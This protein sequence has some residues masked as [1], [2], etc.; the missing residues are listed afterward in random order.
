MF[1]RLSQYTRGVSSIKRRFILIVLLASFPFFAAVSVSTYIFSIV[2]RNHVRQQMVNATH[3]LHS[4]V[5]SLLKANVQTYLRSKVE[6]GSDLLAAAIE[7]AEKTGASLEETLKQSIK[8]LLYFQV[9]GSG[10]FYAIDMQGNVIFHPDE[11]IVGTDQTGK[12]PVDQQLVLRSGYL[13]YMWQNT[14]ESSPRRKALYMRY[15]PRLGWILTVTSYRAEFI[16]MVDRD[17]LKKAV[18]SVSF[19]KSGYSYVVDREGTIIAHPYLEGGNV[20]NHFSKEEYN[21]LMSSFFESDLGYTTYPWQDPESGKT[22][23]KI[24]Y[25]QYLPDFDWVVSTA[26]YLRE[27]N[28]PL[29]AMVIINA[30]IA[31]AVAL[32]LFFA[33]YKITRSVKNPI[34]NLVDVLR[35]SS[36]GDLS[37]RALRGGPKELDTLAGQLNQFLERLEE[38]T[39]SLTTALAERENLLREIQ[40]RVKNNLQ[41]ISSLLNLQK[42]KV[43]TSDTIDVIHITQRRILAI[44]TVYDQMARS[45]TLLEND[46]LEMKPFLVELTDELISSYSMEEIKIETCLQADDGIMLPRSTAV[47]CSLIV[48][49]LMYN[50]LIRIENNGAQGRLEYIFKRSGEKNVLFTLRG[51]VLKGKQLTPRPNNG[52]EKSND[53]HLDLVYVLTE[54]IRG[55]LEYSID[56]KK[57]EYRI[58][59]P[60]S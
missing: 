39:N 54:Q 55:S 49:E 23:T 9:G 18:T 52:A 22:K 31:L 8:H 50:F 3:T 33:V 21:L 13:E 35:K 1:S 6:T 60:V 48:N 4:V 16:D 30:S 20:R 57:L 29:T 11:N 28:S 59:F 38:K 45:R 14:F 5:D 40:H 7:E 2:S 15:L 37:V 36:S 42:A 32:L 27:L 19:G 24:V 46:T 34:I 44:A 53:V 26:V 17:E 58:K 25:H 12:E 41:T 51:T 10:Y 43:K 56:S 47:S